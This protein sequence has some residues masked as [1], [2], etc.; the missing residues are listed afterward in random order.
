MRQPGKALNVPFRPTAGLCVTLA[1]LAALM[2]P[3]PL[4]AQVQ[5]APPQSSMGPS[6]SLV[7]VPAAL[8][9]DDLLRISLE[10]NPNLRQ[11]DL[12]TDVARGK[13]IQ[14][15]LYPNPTVNVIL[16]ELGDRTGPQGINT[17][18]LVTQEIVTGGKLRLNRAVADR[19][20]DQAALA[21]VRQRYSLFTTVR[22]GYFEV[23][24]IRRR[25]EVLLE[26]VKLSTQSFENAQRLRQQ[27]LIADL[28][29]LPFEVEVNRMRA[30]LEAA[31]REEAAAWGRMAASMGVPD[32]PSSPLTGSL[33]MPMPDFAFEPAR[34]IVLRVHPD[35]HIAQVGV[36]RAE[37]ALKRAQVEPIP[38]VTMGSGYVRQNQNRSD[39]WVFQVGLPVPVWNRNQGHIH[40]AQ[41]DLG[42][43]IA[44]VARA[45]N[46]L[47]HRLWDAFGRYAA[48]RQ[49]ADR[50]RTGVLPAAEKTYRLALEAFRGGQFEYL[51][52]LQALRSIQEANLEYVRA[53]ADAW[54]AGSEIAGLLLEDHWPPAAAP[55]LLEAR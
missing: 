12:E 37:L 31:T 38:N 22:Q 54:R 29:L 7:V 13:A 16:D 20:V 34:D 3:Q 11:A 17:L 18:P 25:I 21:V 48:A 39:D 49:R 53:Q 4:A 51:R 15:G 41:A 30:D 33:D 47:T 5:L 36:T 24:A 28:D 46:D 50:Y 40:A 26:L 32:L 19:E 45:R 9:L 55:A 23:L 42:K 43:A 14:A 27:G 35:V 10:Q 52:V 1:G 2:L 8:Q 44:D 6:T